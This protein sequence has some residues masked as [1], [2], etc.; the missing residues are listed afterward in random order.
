V[1]F[2]SIRTKL[3][4]VL[5]P[6]FLVSFVLMAGLGAYFNT[7]ALQKSTDATVLALG[8]DYAHRI[9]YDI[10]ERLAHLE[11]L[12]SM[13][14][15]KEGADKEQM[16]AVLAE[17]KSR[18]GDFDTVAFIAPDGSATYFDGAVK[19]NSD[20]DYFKQIMATKQS[21]VSQPLVAKS[22]GKLSVV[23]AAPVLA[24]GQLVG[25]VIGTYSL[26]NLSD[27]LSTIKFM[28]SGFG[29]LADSS[30][31]VIAH[32]KKPEY[33]GKLKLSEKKVNP[34][35]KFKQPEL[36]DQLINMFNSAAKSDQS[37]VGVYNNQEAG[38]ENVAVFTPVELPGGARWVLTIAAPKDEV[39]RDGDTLGKLMFGIGSFCVVMAIIVIFI[40]S[41]RFA[42]PIALMRD[43]CLLLA[44]G[45]F[46]EREVKVNS[47]DEFGQ[48]AHGF[49][50]MRDNIRNLVVS[51]QSQAELV[52]ASSEELTASAHQ[53]ADAS[54]QV[55]GSVTDIA[56]GMQTLAD[57]AGN[58]AA[59]A[60]ALSASTE[61]VSASAQDVAAI[62]EGTTAA[63]EQG[64]GAV[65][66]AIGQMQT[67]GEGSAAV[68][69]AIAELAQGSG[70][71][72]EI[73]ELI[74]SIAGQ[75]NLLALN[76]AIEAARAG[77]HGR[78]F[79]VVAEEVR[80]LAEES[81]KAASEIGALIQRN[82]S[83]MEQAVSVTKAGADG[84]KAGIAVVNSTGEAFE[85]IVAAIVKLSGEITD[86]SGS[87]N[88]MASG[89]IK[90]GTSLQDIN[91][92][93]REA[94]AETQSVSAA[95]EEQSASIEEIA[96]SSQGLANLAGELQAA[97]AKFRV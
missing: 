20:R 64:R 23:L 18:L 85:K 44:Q 4:L 65:K 54:N 52:A 27:S 29:F 5:V 40:M 3:L 1:N 19:N 86:I 58:I 93:S 59:V 78:G 15:V 63:A 51:V 83:N 45:D 77:E 34:E 56:A 68:E 8:S 92:V 74:S 39:T 12:A 16:V 57:S 48:L 6:L 9:Q 61:H 97:V 43:E 95:T 38:L 60:E 25:M 26:G 72:R 2:N 11:D 46:R 28:D 36:D 80:K 21:C 22:T 17:F 10:Q 89:S 67:I 69:T 42:K 88:E 53:S 49:R 14:T 32:S 94:A 87:I 50:E 62:A 7:K 31:M 47:D 91:K 90:L 33:I 75:T 41:K 30:G 66:Q 71:I 96:S 70:E 24:S 79:A 76:A 55:A 81:N 84:I 82:Q 35:L 13:K 73:V 37:V